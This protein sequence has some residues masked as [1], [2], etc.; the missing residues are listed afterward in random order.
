MFKSFFAGN[1]RRTRVLPLVTAVFVAAVFFTATPALAATD[2]S[3]TMSVSPLAVE[4]ASINNNFTF[5]F[6]N[7]S[8][9]FGGS[10]ILTLTVPS[11]WTNPQKTTSGNAGFVTVISS[12][13]GNSPANG[14]SD[15][16]VSSN[17]ATIKIDQCD[18]GDTFDLQ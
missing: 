4:Q 16:T 11:G 17:I 2:G 6:T 15:I 5:H 10:S 1:L 13:C 14:T 3:G 18:A 8:T 9:N 12:T 7:T